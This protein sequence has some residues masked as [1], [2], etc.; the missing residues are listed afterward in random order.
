MHHRQIHLPL[1]YMLM[2]KLPLTVT[3]LYFPKEMDF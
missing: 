3:L 1:M 2:T